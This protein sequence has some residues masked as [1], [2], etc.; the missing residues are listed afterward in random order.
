[1]FFIIYYNCYVMLNSAEVLGVAASILR[2][3]G[4]RFCVNDIDDVTVLVAAFTSSNQQRLLL[5]VS[6]QG[7]CIVYTTKGI[8]Y[9]PA[10]SRGELLEAITRANYG[11]H[12]GRFSM[13][14]TDGEVRFQTE[15]P[16]IGIQPTTLASLLVPLQKINLQTHERY[17]GAFREVVEGRK[18]GRKAIDDLERNSSSYAF[19]PFLITARIVFLI[20]NCLY[21]TEREALVESWR[22]QQL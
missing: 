20:F 22:V 12:T 11:L 5:A 15:L 14:C 6:F 3:D 19:L 17:Y 4:Y 1:M 8:E 10:S 2:S 18:T 9:A 21:A 13:D 16:L 7:G